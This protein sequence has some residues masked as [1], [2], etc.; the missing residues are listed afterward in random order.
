VIA[1]FIVASSSS[2]RANLRTLVAESGF[3][4]VG[5]SADLAGVDETLLEA[6]P[7]IILIDASRDLLPADGDALTEIAAQSHVVLLADRG[8]EMQLGQAFRDGALAVLPREVSAPQLRA[9]L[10]AVAEGLLVVH[11]SAV[12]TLVPA[13]TQA[14]S[15][16]PP[17]AEPLTKR[18]REVLQMVAAG[19]ANKEIAAQLKISDHTAKFHVASILGKLGASTRTE[20]VAIGLRYGLILL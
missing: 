6:E 17:L 1:V 10:R 18:E 13:P 8:D 4:I 3:E 12:N 14:L 11:P 5:S 15:S 19:L 7:D 9:A 16:P 2:A 20:A